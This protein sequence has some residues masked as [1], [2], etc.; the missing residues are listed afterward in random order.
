VGLITGFGLALGWVLYRATFPIAV[1]R[2]SS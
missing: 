2:F 1:E